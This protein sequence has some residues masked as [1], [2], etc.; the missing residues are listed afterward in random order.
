MRLHYQLLDAAEEDLE[1]VKDAQKEIRE[2]ENREIAVNTDVILEAI[3]N[4]EIKIVANKNEKIG[5][6]WAKT[7]YSIPYFDDVFF[8]KLTYLKKDYRK[9]FYPF[10]LQAIKDFA[11]QSG[12]KEVFGDVF[13]SNAENLKVHSKLAEPIFTVFKAKI[14]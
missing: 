14:D 10:I 7:N 12:Y 5:F 11:K 2:I 1:M 13:H 3:K 8:I 6:L 4:K 9:F